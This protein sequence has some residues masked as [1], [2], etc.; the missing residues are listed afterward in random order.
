MS[1]TKLGKGFIVLASAV[2][3]FACAGKE[4]VSNNNAEQSQETETTTVTTTTPAADVE[5]AE[6]RMA[7][8]NTETR[9]ARVVYFDLDDDTIK[10]E[11]RALLEAHAWF[12]S[13]N[14]AITVV[15]EGHC[16][17]R[18]TPAYNLAL[19]ERRAKAI[20]QLLMINGVAASQIR[21]VSKGE[22]EPAIDGHDESAWSQNRR[23]VLEY[24]G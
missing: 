2:F 19:G 21:T 9:Q 1:I 12:L 17:E 20:A 23:G 8:I 5:T 16:D 22:E 3:L 4:T 10:P 11:A 6:E 15:V 14:N 24:E 7:R 13:R 18:G